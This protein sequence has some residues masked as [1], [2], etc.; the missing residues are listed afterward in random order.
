MYIAPIA[1]IYVALMMSVAEATNTNGSVLG[2]VEVRQEFAGLLFCN[3][4]GLLKSSTQVRKR[5]LGTRALQSTANFSDFT[6][7]F[8][9]LLIDLGALGLKSGCFS[10]NITQRDINLR[11]V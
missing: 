6:R 7:E 11:G 10:V 1:W 3:T 5:W 2:A 9:N 8:V 4:Q